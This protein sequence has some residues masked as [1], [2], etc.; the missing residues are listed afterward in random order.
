MSR[1]YFKRAANMKNTTLKQLRTFAMLARSRTMVAAA[2]LLGI[3][4][5]AVTIQLKLLEDS[6][7]LP[8]VERT[9]TGNKLTAAGREVLTAAARVDQILSECGTAIEHLKGLEGVRQR[10]EW[11]PPRIFRSLLLAHSAGLIPAS[12]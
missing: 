2:E 3:T 1:G 11:S 5:P 7:G 9:S 12:R 10:S 6:V 8:L 4:P